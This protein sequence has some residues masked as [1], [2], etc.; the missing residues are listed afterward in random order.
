MWEK[1]FDQLSG[2]AN[3]EGHSKVVQGYVAE[4]G[5]RLGLWVSNQKANKDGMSPERRARLE[6]LPGWVWRVK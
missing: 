1:G 2:F 6:S 3:R 4:G 5:Y